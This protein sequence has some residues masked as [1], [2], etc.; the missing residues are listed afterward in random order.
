VKFG[1]GA[2]SRSRKWEAAAEV[3]A[4]MADAA[5]GRW[6][7]EVTRY[8]WF[9][10]LVAWL[11]WV[12]DIMDTALFNFAKVPMLEDMLGGAQAYQQQGP[13]IEGLIQMVFLVGW[14][15][16]GL[17]FGIL[18]DRW[19]RARTMILTILLYCLF[20]G[21]TALCQTWEQVLVVRFFTAL[22]I[23]G[24][25][26]AGAALVAE[27]F[28][29][30]ARA[31]AAAILQ[32]AAA[33]GPVL[34]ATANLQLAAHSWRW[35]FVV[36]ILPAFVTVLIRKGVK[37]PEK[38]E[39]RERLPSVGAALKDLFGHPVWRRNAIVAMLIGTVGI[40]GAGTVSFWLPNLVNAASEGLPR[41][42]IQQRMSYATY[43]LHIGTLLGVFAFPWLAERVGRKRA[44]VTGFILAPVSI[45]V[46]L[47]GGE[48]YA[49]LFLMA[50]LMSFFTIGLTAT[51]ALYFPELFPTRIRATGAG[52]AYNTA[53]I[54]QAP[55]PWFT[56]LVIGMPASS[57][58]HGVAVAAGA[59]L[60]GLGALPFAQETRGKPL[61]EDH[62][63]EPL[64]TPDQPA[65]VEA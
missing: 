62:A 61:P 54:V 45:W 2:A 33:V 21:V 59:Y 35:L 20:T 47:Y 58:V 43:M 30:R 40:A 51:F 16:G 46:A 14:A 56:G 1:E 26:A 9:V 6:W 29:N 23:G 15:I 53:R 28:P 48:S 4:A 64:P 13:Q 38:W 3:E 27:V 44:L 36:G 65:P 34:A 24:E 5:Q 52:F 31:A 60:V 7:H 19:G 25:W 8:Q 49:R 10:L 11:G 32:T 17:V 42:M 12:F 22:G 18:A 63:S 50:P 41:E 57:P 37:E 55:V 39:R